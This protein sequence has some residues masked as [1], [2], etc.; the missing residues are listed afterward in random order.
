MDVIIWLTSIVVTKENFIQSLF[1]HT[2]RKKEFSSTMAPQHWYWSVRNFKVASYLKEYVRTT[3]RLLEWYAGKANGILRKKKLKRDAVPR[4]F[5]FKQNL[6]Y[7][8]HTKRAEKRTQIYMCLNSKKSFQ[9]IWLNLHSDLSRR[10]TMYGQKCTHLF[11]LK[12]YSIF[13]QSEFL[14]QSK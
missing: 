1:E 10:Q 3:L 12:H 11:V 8:N 9:Y 7:D 2:T 13:Y 6:V 4:I 14:L 5:A